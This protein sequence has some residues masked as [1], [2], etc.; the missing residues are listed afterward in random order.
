TLEWN[1]L[2]NCCYDL[3]LNV[4]ETAAQLQLQCQYS[5]ELFNPDTIQRWLRHYEIL[6]SAMV[7]DPGQR[8]DQIGR[9]L[10]EETRQLPENLTRQGQPEACGNNE[11]GAEPLNPTEQGLARIWR[12]IIG[13]EEVGRNDDFFDVGGHSLLATQIISRITRTFNVELPLRTIFEAPTLGTLAAAITQAQREQPE[14]AL[15]IPRRR[16]EAGKLLERLEQL[17]ETE[18]QELLRNSKLKDLLP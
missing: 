5:T 18:L 1:L 7:T 15:A 8:L 9:L 2:G 4:A 3:N 17:S 6:L 13:L 11:L 12:E 10:S 16:S 14:G